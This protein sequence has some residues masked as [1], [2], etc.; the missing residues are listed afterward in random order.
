VV[1]EWLTKKK[2]ICA[3][4]KNKYLRT[5]SCWL[6]GKQ[7]W[8]VQVTQVAVLGSAQTKEKGRATAGVGVTSLRSP[9]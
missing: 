1:E 7:R 4:A 9:T 5:M 2:E 8:L 3:S 6:A